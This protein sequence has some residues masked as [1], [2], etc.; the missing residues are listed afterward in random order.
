M[1]ADVIAA[2]AALV[3]AFVAFLVASAQ[4]IQQY[5]VS[6]QLIRLCDSVVYNRMPGQ[7]H[8]IWQYSQFRFRVVY[9][10]PQVH[11]LPDLW[12]GISSNVRPMP[13][14]AAPVPNLKVERSNST[15]AALAGEASW[16][17]FVRAVQHSSGRS[18]RYVMVDGDADRCP[19]DLPVVP[20]QLSMREMVVMALSAGMQVTDVSFTSQTI[21]MQGDAGTITCS[22]HP[23]LGSLIHFAQ[24]Q[25][26][27]NHGI[28]VQGG[29]IQADWVVRMLDIV[30]VAGRRFDTVDRKHYEE[31]EGS[32]IKASNHKASMLEQEPESR[33]V[34]PSKNTVRRRR[35]NHSSADNVDDGN[36]TREKGDEIPS[37]IPLKSSEEDN[38]A[39]LHRPQ[40][41]EW[42]FILRPKDPVV[43]GNGSFLLAEPA[44]VFHSRSYSHSNDHPN[45]MHIHPAQ[46]KP[47]TRNTGPILP[48]QEPNHGTEIKADQEQQQATLYSAPV[49]YEL[50]TDSPPSPSAIDLESGPHSDEPSKKPQGG[51]L[52]DVRKEAES[53]NSKTRESNQQPVQSST[54]PLLTEGTRYTGHTRVLSE[55]LVSPRRDKESIHDQARHEFVVDKW[56]RA[57]QQR[58]KER[59]RGRSRNDPDRRATSRVGTTFGRQGSSKAYRKPAMERPTRPKK[60]AI[61][62]RTSSLSSSEDDHS[63]VFG[64]RASARRRKGSLSERDTTRPISQSKYR[65]SIYR[66]NTSPSSSSSVSPT[67]GA[68]E[69]HESTPKLR[70]S[71]A[72][73]R[74]RQRNPE[75]ATFASD[76]SEKIP[77]QDRSSPQVYILNDTDP[78]QYENRS[79][80]PFMERGR[81]RVKVLEPSE[82][83]D[84][85][86][87][88]LSP[89]LPSRGKQ[90][91]KCV[92]RSPTKRFSEDPDFVR[93]GIAAPRD[94]D[95]PENARRTK[96][97]RETIIPEALDLG[98]E[99][100]Y[101]EKDHVI[102]LRALSRE[103]IN[104]YAI[105]TQRIREQRQD[106]EQAPFLHPEDQSQIND[107]ENESSSE[108][109]DGSQTSFVRRRG[110]EVGNPVPLPRDYRRQSSP[111]DPIDLDSRT[112]EELAPK[113]HG[114]VGQDEQGVESAE[115]RHSQRSA[116]TGEPNSEKASSQRRSNPQ[117]VNR[118]HTTHAEFDR[119][120]KR[121]SSSI[122]TTRRRSTFHQR[123]LSDEDILTYAEEIMILQS[124]HILKKLTTCTEQCKDVVTTLQFVRSIQPELG[125]SVMDMHDLIKETNSAVK[126]ILLYIGP[127]C[128][129]KR[130]AT[131]VNMEL[132][133]LLHGLQSSLDMIQANFDLFDITPLTSN[134]R[135]VAWET[136]LAFFELEYT[137]PL[138]EFLR[139][140]RSFAAEIASNFQ[141]GISTSPEADIMMKRL[142][143]VS[144]VRKD[145]PIPV[146]LPERSPHRRPAS[147]SRSRYFRS[148]SRFTDS[149]LGSPT[150]NN[151][152]GSNRFLTGPLPLPRR[153]SSGLDYNRSGR[154]VEGNRSHSQSDTDHSLGSETDA[155]S[156]TLATSKSDYTGD[157]KWFW[158][159][160]ADVLPGY[161]ATPWRG[162]FPCAECIGTISVLLTSLEP[163]TKKTNF[164]Y[165]ATQNHNRQ[166]LH[167][168][169]TTYPSYAHNAAGGVVVAGTYRAT[170]F[171]SFKSPIAPL[172]LYKGYEHQ[173]DRN[174]SYTAQ[175]VIDST[176]EIMGL[177][178]WL[179][180]SGRQ[181]EITEGLSGLLKS[182]PTL[183][184]QIMTDFH[185]EFTSVDRTSKDGGSRIINTISD[186]ILVY[187]K[188]HGLT[189]AEQLFCLVALLRTVKM[190]LCVAR[191]TDTTMLRDVLIYDVQ[192]YL[193]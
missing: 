8:R 37:T 33:P 123:S 11:L 1:D 115:N 85:R 73:A 7:G 83:D 81:K 92:L 179:S 162:L 54:P 58:R 189:E 137:C 45:T 13:P 17:S 35:P 191:G 180:I 188:E 75:M 3:V 149:P 30:T 140:I 50:R 62:N 48:F 12:L 105:E 21:S 129:D 28:Q 114:Q 134:E 177:D 44:R 14:D 155:S 32:W 74:G 87:R 76:I 108:N 67:L 57:F 88:R 49:T 152:R 193:A 25:A 101:E 142:A 100:Y 160:Q 4:A 47:T 173:V 166:W 2:I 77:Y 181:P 103:E 190:A 68:Y 154:N 146:R 113:R 143:E 63:V 38:I 112:S 98:R 175:T 78:S 43:E 183:I 186:S 80:S 148:P 26:F 172:E 136:T 34:D 127:Q 116:Y 132:G 96:I 93:P 10:I 165:A 135:Q 184:Q 171:S 36:S 71:A 90:P 72:A 6:G 56:E 125:A 107:S 55:G 120:I 187:L 20:M 51:R 39:I 130:V 167:Q 94:K 128:E 79:P 59:S 133:T 46:R 69:R 141:V 106:Q 156:I 192:V 15:S 185:L 164:Q 124:D 182:L 147:Q 23:I 99:R 102:V 70:K 84:A 18:M 126:I 111:D 169:R 29:T 66:Q 64:D 158:I 91:S 168:G 9:S 31:D 24:K 95:V 151:L 42:S 60:L 157:M 40:D 139:I 122:S 89:S 82:R 144:A 121:T 131:I 150:K 117:Q 65:T 53:Q 86:V 138:E 178:T 5:L 170:I 119:P 41:G 109:S 176:A 110:P 104:H 161:F 153:T 19:S 174:L 27:E 22:R 159:C 61:K 145:S 52:K 16:V 97:R 118:R 163:F